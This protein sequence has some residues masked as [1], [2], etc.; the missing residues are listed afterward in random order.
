M[1]SNSRHAYIDIPAAFKAVRARICITLRLFIIRTVLQRCSNHNIQIK[2]T[3][4]C[5]HQLFLLSL[6][7]FNV[8][9]FERDRA[10]SILVQTQR[11]I[12][13]RTREQPNITLGVS[14]L[15][16]I[17]RCSLDLVN[18]ITLT[19][20]EFVFFGCVIAAR[21]NL[22]ELLQMWMLRNL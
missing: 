7:H 10:V 22:C 6:L 4:I 16:P 2:C 20:S 21:I 11:K 1:S 5:S 19:K 14:P 13:R 18:P 12:T 15:P 9:C 8:V 17:F 3:N